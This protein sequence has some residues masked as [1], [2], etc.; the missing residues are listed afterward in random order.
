MPTALQQ[1][2]TNPTAAH[3]GPLAA[4]LLLSSLPGYFRIENSELPWYIQQPE[5]WCYPIQTLL[6]ALLLFWWRD[7]Y[8]PYLRALPLRPGH[9]LLAISLGLVGIAFWV[10]P[11]A[12]FRLLPAS[13]S[14]PAWQAHLGITDR[15]QGFDPGLLS[16]HPALFYLTILLRFARSTLL[17][18]IVEELVWRGYLMRSIMA[19]ARPFTSVP[20]GSHHWKAWLISTLL[21]TFIHSAPD[22][23]AAF[24]WA[25][26]MYLLTIRTRSLLACILMH[27]IGNLS[28]GLYILHT[29][30]YGYW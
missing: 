17:V 12:I 3:V 30:Q 27:A 26:L 21:V 7:H 16:G 23:P 24:L 20:F 18:P 22:W 2:R 11:G 29:S 19:G 8:R 28:L 15:S 13:D 6:T 9:L 1:L 10:L 4:F 14:P 5:H 25:N